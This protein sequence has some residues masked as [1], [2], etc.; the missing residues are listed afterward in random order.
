MTNIEKVKKAQRDVELLQSALAGV[1]G[2][3][4]TV[5]TIVETADE[6]R[7]GARRLVK[8]GLVL[9]VVGVSVA[10][11]LRIRRARDPKPSPTELRST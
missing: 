3:L 11:V 2:G 9:A 6:V 10:I 1:H 5:E 8:L 4:D 7:R